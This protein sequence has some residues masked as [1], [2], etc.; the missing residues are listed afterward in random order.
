MP[1]YHLLC[2]TP[3]F[4]WT[5]EAYT[6]FVALKKVLTGPTLLATP[7]AKEP[8]LMYIA[9]TNRIINTVIVIERPEEGRAYPI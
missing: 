1:L 9:A 6:R 2:K 7:E 4:E 8:S 5:E 3:M